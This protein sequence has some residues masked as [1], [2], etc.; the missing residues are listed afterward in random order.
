[1][2]TMQLMTTGEWR[3]REATFRF[4][5]IIVGARANVALGDVEQVIGDAIQEVPDATIVVRPPAHRWALVAVPAG[6][7]ILAFVK[8][9]ASRPGIAYAEPDFLIEGSADVDPD[10][11]DRGLQDW[12]SIVEARRAWGIT[13]GRS[14]VWIAVL[15]SGIPIRSGLLAHQDLRSRRYLIQHDAANHDYTGT[16][17]SHF[18]TDADGHGTHVTGIVAADTDNGTGV[19]GVNWKSSVYVARVLDENNAGSVG[20]V[21]HAMADL[22]ALVGGSPQPRVVV[23]MSFH[24]RVEAE[25]ASLYEVCRE[26]YTG[27]YL[28][29]CAA[30]FYQPTTGEGPFVTDFPARYA[31]KFKHVVSVGSSGSRANPNDVVSPIEGTTEPANENEVTILAPGVDVYSTTLDAPFYGSMTGTSMAT[32]VVAG[33]ASLM[34]SVAPRL[35]PFSIKTLLRITGSTIGSGDRTYRRVNARRAVLTAKWLSWGFPWW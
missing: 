28:L 6:T 1:M 16:P 11:P 14:E 21:K 31:T 25:I 5:R 32:P 9:V 22:M 27:Q 29:C 35:S 4:D 12:I 26:T 23:N 15:D 13:T 7:N 30:T 20:A 17:L 3:G 8:H 10:D 34:W 24:T 33:V 19:A 18:P 2:A